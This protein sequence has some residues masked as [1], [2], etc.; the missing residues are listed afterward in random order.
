MLEYLS[1]YKQ[2]I[3][4]EYYKAIK[5]PIVYLVFIASFLVVLGVS[6]VY[7]INV[8][9]MVDLNTNPWDHFINRTLAVN[10]IFMMLPFV[11]LLTSYSTYLEV[12]SNTWK[13][14]YTLPQ[15][16]SVIYVA[17]LM[18]IIGMLMISLLTYGA[19]VL[20]LGL[21]L[22]IAYPIFEFRYYVPDF[23]LFLYDVTHLFVALLGVISFQYWLS[24]RTKSIILPIGVGLL[25][26]MIGFVLFTANNAYA[27]Y[28]PY[29]FAMKIKGFSMVKNSSADFCAWW[30]MSGGINA[31]ACIGFTLLG[32]YQERGVRG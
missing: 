8:A 2:T 32:V 23:S 7:L 5:T 16:R 25:G 28:F 1:T 19:L 21:F 20:V 3:L 31:A 6:I 18:V 15:N 30:G 22:D 14:L 10:A 12:R 4:G 26:F 11:V 9:G 29:A 13:Y 17:K 27:D 24:I